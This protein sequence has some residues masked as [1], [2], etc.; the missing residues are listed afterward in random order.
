MSWRYHVGLLGVHFYQQV[1]PTLEIS[2]MFS[3]QINHH[4]QFF[5]SGI[6][7]LFLE[8]SQRAL[9]VLHGLDPPLQCMPTSLP[10]S[11]TWAVPV[12]M[13]TCSSQN[14]VFV[15]EKCCLPLHSPFSSHILFFFSLLLPTILGYYQQTLS[16]STNSPCLLTTVLDQYQ[17]SLSV[18]TINSWLVPQLCS[19]Q[20]FRHTH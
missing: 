15:M 14:T 10:H 16:I 18:I 8:F 13:L 12:L 1:F 19:Y 4:A 11:C 3:M 7:S 17:Q 5:I 6:I 2:F 9:G 20:C